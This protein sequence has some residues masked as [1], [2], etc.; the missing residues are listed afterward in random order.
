MNWGENTE[1]IHCAGNAQLI[2]K[3]EEGRTRILFNKRIRKEII[4]NQLS[5]ELEQLSELAMQGRL[6]GNQGADYLM[7]QN[8]F[9]N[10]K[11]SDDLISFWY[12]ARHNVLPCYYTQSLWYT[13]QSA[14]CVLGGYSVES[15][16]HVLDGCSKL[17]NNYSKRHDR[18]VEKIGREI[19]SRENKV[20][21]YKTVRTALRE[22]GLRDEDNDEGLLNFKPDIVIKQE[23]KLIILDVACP[24]DLYFAELYEAKIN[25]Y[26]D[27]Q[28]YLTTNYME[29]KV[30]AITVGS[31][32]T[33]HK[34]ALKVLMDI[35][36]PK[37]KAKG[38]LKWSS[39][40]SMIGSR[41]I[42]NLRCKLVSEN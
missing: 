9:R 20:I 42:W 39:T 10:Y 7:S 12:K 40:S 2:L 34:K 27:L 21:V 29:C 18:I 28:R 3:S 36:M 4:E 6:V 8:I 33:I 11:L 17:K 37:S 35:G 26:R 38:L 14:S 1:D 13:N 24:Y 5:K 25:K 31:F 19:K 32:G 30:D 41:Q 23:N 15:T 22:S 16:T